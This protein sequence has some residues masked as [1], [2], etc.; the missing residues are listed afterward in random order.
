MNFIFKTTTF[1]LL[2]LITSL[3]IV[4]LAVS[5]PVIFPAKGQSDEQ[6]DKDKYY[7]Y[8]WAKKNSGFD[9][10]STSNQA[11]PTPT[12]KAQTG[13]VL[14]GAAR[15][16][17]AGV[18][19]GDNSKSTRRGAAL[20]AGIGGIR[21]ASAN[22]RQNAAPPPNQNTKGKDSYNRSFAACLEGKGYTVK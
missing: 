9:P 8:G 11:P 4:N 3:L 19:I 21:Q 12:K 18:I 17:V 16:A 13:G 6:L 15:G 5:D 1:S 22:S 7:C 20:G 10:L 2:T 14:R